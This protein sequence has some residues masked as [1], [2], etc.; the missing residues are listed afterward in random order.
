MLLKSQPLFFKVSSP[1]SVPQQQGGKLNRVS[2]KRN[3]E[4]MVSENSTITYG[5]V[6]ET[7]MLTTEFAASFTSSGVIPKLSMVSLVSGSLMMK[8]SG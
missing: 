7:L 2:K 4:S 6:A 1:V 8:S 5:F 3:G